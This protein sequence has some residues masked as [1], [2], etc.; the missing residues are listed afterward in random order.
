M[1]TQIP[2][3]ATVEA[4]YIEL[5]S[6]GNMDARVQR[7][8]DNGFIYDALHY[9]SGRNVNESDADEIRIFVRQQP[10]SSQPT[11]FA[12]PSTEHF[13]NAAAQLVAGTRM[14]AFSL[15]LALTLGTM[16][17]RRATPYQYDFDEG[18][19]KLVEGRRMAID[20]AVV[21][22][23]PSEDGECDEEENDVDWGDVG[24]DEE[25]NDNV[26]SPSAEPKPN[27][28]YWN[29]HPDTGEAIIKWAKPTHDVMMISLNVP[30]RKSL[31]ISRVPENGQSIPLYT[32]VVRDTDGELQVM[33]PEEYTKYKRKHVVVVGN[34]Q[35][36]PQQSSAAKRQA[37]AR[38]VKGHRRP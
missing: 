8:Y 23:C 31:F 6:I 13:D 1:T 37:A 26:I 17:M 24:S 7:A 30:W 10:R 15:G 12:F 34:P 21:G 36:T 19:I 28:M 35:D 5:C 11:Y 32:Y 3:I 27:A 20:A 16:C 38:A 4:K 22:A 14:D 2:A 9:L 18:A 29:G 25:E 33:N